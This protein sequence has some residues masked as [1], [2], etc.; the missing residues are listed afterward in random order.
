MPTDIEKILAL[1]EDKQRQI[2][3]LRVILF[4]KTGSGPSNIKVDTLAV[5]NINAKES[6]EVIEINPRI[7][8]ED[9]IGFESEDTLITGDTVTS[10]LILTG[11]VRSGGTYFKPDQ[12][13]V[14]TLG[15]A[16]KRWSD[17]RSVLIN[18]ADYGFDN[19]WTLTEH[20]KVH[21]KEPGIAILDENNN[22]VAF[23]GKERIYCAGLRDIKLLD[24]KKT[25]KEERV[26][27]AK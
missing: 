25:T 16:S 20:D 15:Q 7:I 10:D 9:G 21:I 22:L 12:D 23:I 11:N 18:G 24:W 2:D 5:K 6:A 4:K 1:L 17:V 26:K 19:G 13:N 14:I 27:M 8:V 3:D